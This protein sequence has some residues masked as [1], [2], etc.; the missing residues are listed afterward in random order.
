MRVNPAKWL[1]IRLGGLTSV[2]ILGGVGN[3]TV[4]L[5]NLGVVVAFLSLVNTLRDRSA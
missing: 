2:N 1:Q 3:M 5:V 4:R